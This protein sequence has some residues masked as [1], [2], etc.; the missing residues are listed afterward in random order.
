MKRREFVKSLAAAQLAMMVAE[1]GCDSRKEPTAQTEGGAANSKASTPAAGGTKQL[2]V[3]VHGMFAIVVDRKGAK[4]TYLKAPAVGGKAPHRYRAQTFTVD[5]KDPSNLIPGWQNDYEVASAQTSSSVEF[6]RGPDSKLSLILPDNNRLIVDVSTKTPGVLPYWTV[7]LPV[8]DDILPLRAT[9]FNYLDSSKFINGSFNESYINNGM[10]F[11]QQF[12]II[13]VLTYNKIPIDNKVNF[14]SG[15]YT[16]EVPFDA[17]IGRLH[18]FAEP[19]AASTDRKHLEMALEALDKL[20]VPNLTLHFD[21]SLLDPDMPLGRDNKVPYANVLLCEE[22]SLD[23]RSMSCGQFENS[24]TIDTQYSAVFA[25]KSML[26]ELNELRAA[27][28]QKRST[29]TRQA[30]KP[31][32]NC[33]SVISRQS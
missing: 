30:A 25:Y 31:P 4:K 12:P 32:R 13:Y 10:N 5:P 6:D 23:E 3:V 9:P 20:F 8:P 18:L 24:P 1:A 28:S 16:Q 17:G 22:R 14:T 33:M 15:G 7:G 27:A 11:F 29:L 19:S 2:N 26:E 21:P